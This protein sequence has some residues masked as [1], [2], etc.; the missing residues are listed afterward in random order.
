[1]FFTLFRQVLDPQIPK[2][3]PTPVPQKSDPAGFAMQA[4]MEAKDVRVLNLIQVRIDDRR[5]IEANGHMR[6]DRPD[7][8]GVPL[9]DR[10][11]MSALGCHD[12]IN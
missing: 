3:N 4:A 2:I 11:Q 10:L 1:M 12:V 9:A 6:A 7:L 8:F 5:A